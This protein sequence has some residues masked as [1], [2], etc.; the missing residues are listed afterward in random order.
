MKTALTV[1]FLLFCRHPSVFA[2][3]QESFPTHYIGIGIGYSFDHI[4]DQNFSPLHQKGQGLFYRVFYEHRKENSLKVALTYGN[5]SLKSGANDDFTS[6]HYFVDVGISYLKN[7]AASDAVTKY[8]L[9][10]A[11]GLRITY[12]DWKDQDAFSYVATNGLSLS[13][14]VETKIN[15]KQRIG[16]TVAIPVVQFLSRPPYNGIDEFIIAHQDNPAAIIFNGKLASF[17]TYKAISWN[18]NYRKEI[19][20]HFNW[21][22]NYDFS[23]QTVDQEQEYKSISNRISTS[24]LYKF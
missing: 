19:S 16:T 15:D 11:Y 1:L 18:I 9:G 3:A 23:L 24:V 12:L 5:N 8:Y 17:K 21:N 14:A 6:A 7:L 4:S 20:P 2:Q 10:G 13:G 22:V